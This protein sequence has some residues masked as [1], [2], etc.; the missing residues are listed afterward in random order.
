[1]DKKTSKRVTEPPKPVKI[2]AALHRKLS[3]AAAELGVRIGA[4]AERMLTDG[5]GGVA[6]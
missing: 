3:V 2:P 6:R 1:V 5:L 4:L